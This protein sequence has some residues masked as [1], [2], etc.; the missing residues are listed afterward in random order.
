M[1]PTHAHLRRWLL[2]LPPAPSPPTYAALKAAYGSC[3][4]IVLRQ[5]SRSPRR[6]Q[7]PIILDIALPCHHLYG[8]T[9]SPRNALYATTQSLVAGLYKLICVIAAKDSI[10]T[11]DSE[12][13]DARVILLAYPRN[14]KLIR[15]SED[16]DSEQE[17]QG[18]VI[19]LHT[20]ARC[21]RSWDAIYAV[22]SEEGEELLKNFLSKG[23]SERNITRVRGG[24]VQVSSLEHPS[25]TDNSST[26]KNHLSVALGGT[27]DHLHIG[28]KLLL[29]MFAF[30]LGRRSPSDD[31]KIP[32]VLTIGI[33]GDE[34]LKNKKY[35]ELLE[36]WHERQQ[37]VHSFLSSLIHFGQPDDGRIHIEEKS[38]P[39]PNGHAVHVTYPSNLVI[40]YVEI[41]DPFGPTITDESISALVISA[42]TRSGGTAVNDK[43]VEKGWDPL[44]VFEVDVLDAGE[45]ENMDKTFQSKL[46]STEIRRKLGERPRSKGQ[47]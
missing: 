2:L 17:F 31:D 44:E 46:S 14:G 33:T 7:E 47:L 40:K 38:D 27:F 42:E 3:L 20:L 23:S 5:L 43:R 36:T 45:E 24:I 35:P 30:V 22:E 21:S 18:P 26:L 19:S 6:T 15:S 9:N 41:W 37:A 13:V 8:R 25:P 16:E 12:G 28:H 39:G 1:A 11:E 29:T 34:L 4:F 32:S 10:D